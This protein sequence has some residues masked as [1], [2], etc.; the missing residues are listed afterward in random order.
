MN[1]FLEKG[2]VRKDGKV[3]ALGRGR[4]IYKYYLCIPKPIVV[5]I[6]NVSTK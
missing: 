1:R 3:E 5:A 2:I 6:F 4:P